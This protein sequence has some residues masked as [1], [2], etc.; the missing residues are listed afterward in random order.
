L[1]TGCRIWL[2]VVFTV[3]VEVIG[4]YKGCTV[5]RGSAHRLKPGKWLN[6]ELIQCVAALVSNNDCRLSSAQPSRK[7]SH[8]FSTSSCSHMMAG[9]YSYQAVLRWTGTV[10]ILQLDKLLTP[11]NN[12]S[13]VCRM[14]VPRQRKRSGHYS[15][16]PWRSRNSLA[17]NS[18][19]TTTKL[20]HLQEAYNYCRSL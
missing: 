15:Q 12:V 19:V 5:M 7:R 8:T 2:I 14:V 3:T 17:L 6:D 13:V 20:I 4:N 18:N 9:G 16:P 10:D 1:H 11:I